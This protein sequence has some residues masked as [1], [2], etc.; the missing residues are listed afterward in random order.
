MAIS[1]TTAALRLHR[2][3]EVCEHGSTHGRH[4]SQK[5][6]HNGCGFPGVKISHSSL[7]HRLGAIYAFLLSPPH[8]RTRTVRTQFQRT[9][10]NKAGVRSFPPT[11]FG[12][13]AL[14]CLW[15]PM[16][17]GIDPMEMT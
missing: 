17:S 14:T 15:E 4:K 3:S 7:V 2:V 16:S 8:L 11:L 1:Q 6:N 12:L 9:S 10:D 5:G 13:Y